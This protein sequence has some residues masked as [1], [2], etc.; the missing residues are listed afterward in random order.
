M[1]TKDPF[2]PADGMRFPVCVHLPELSY[3]I[4]HLYIKRHIKR[5]QPVSLT[6]GNK[7]KILNWKLA[8]KEVYINIRF[9]KLLV[10]EN[11]E[12]NIKSATIPE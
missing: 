11:T 3:H 10:E 6:C 1:F 8:G 9:W 5:N 12:T 4:Q 2:M 7:L